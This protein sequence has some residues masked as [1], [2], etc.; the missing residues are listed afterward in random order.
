MSNHP[1]RITS[2]LPSV[3]VVAVLLLATVVASI[4]VSSRSTV[5]VGVSMASSGPQTMSQPAAQCG[6]VPVPLASASTYAVLAGSTVTS[7]GATALTGDLGLSPGSAVTGFPPGTVTGLQNVDNLAAKGAEANLTTAYANAT[8]AS[9]ANCP[10]TL[11]NGENLAGLTLAP[12]LYWSAKTL[13]IEGGALTLSGGGNPN[14]VFVFQLGSAFTT[15]SGAKVILTNGAQAGN[16]FW[17]VGSSATIGTTSTVQGT[18]LAADSISLLTGATL[19]GRAL[20]KT[21]EVS[22]EGATVVVPTVTTSTTYTVTFT[23]S[24]LPSR[25]NWVATVAG[26]WASSQT[27][28]IE[29]QVANGTYGFTAGTSAAYAA[30][31]SS[32]SVTVNGGSAAKAIAFSGSSGPGA[33]RVSFLG[34]GLA[35]GTNW[36]VSL[37]GV[38]ESS[39]TTAID[40][41]VG[42]GT[43]SFAPG[44]VAGYTASPMSGNLVVNGAA[45]SET[46]VYTAGGPGTYNVTFTEAGLVAGTNWTVTLN[47][48]SRSSSTPTL[49]F[50][51]SNGTNAFSV[52]AIS[53]SSS[54][55]TF[56]NVTVS[57]ASMGQSIHF[58]GNGAASGG[59]SMWGWALIALAVIA[60]V[61]VAGALLLR[62]RTKAP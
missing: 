7:T 15:T 5:G 44:S 34:S 42:N 32:G 8:P 59:L 1:N 50:N 14:A 4:A 45:V 31:P 25:T 28:T 6:Q 27:N 20:A 16:V 56:G 9:R 35:S 47:G 17:Q 21:G 29:F 24:G 54:T 2:I 57:G 55:P 40:F 48:V 37:N 33:Y 23:A 36:S 18:I 30:N 26:A 22:L 39:T 10:V 13:N 3:F 43:Y 51:A 11:T 12:G 19:D 62:N 52:G 41:T 60:A 61:A 38:P 49:V 58:S 46:L 53:G